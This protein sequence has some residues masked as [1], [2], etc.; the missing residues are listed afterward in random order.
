MIS[1]GIS[2]VL[3]VCLSKALHMAYI[4]R[5]PR[6][7]ERG[8]IQPEQTIPE[9]VIQAGIGFEIFLP[10]AV[11]NIYEWTEKTFYRHPDF[12]YFMTGSMSSGSPRIFVVLRAPFPILTEWKG[13]VE[14]RLDDLKLF[15]GDLYLPGFRFSEYPKLHYGV[16]YQY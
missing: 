7:T 11:E 8:A 14:M 2:I 4:S 12:T 9:P 1:I 13:P 16:L 10:T 15:L 3:T 6:V 5:K